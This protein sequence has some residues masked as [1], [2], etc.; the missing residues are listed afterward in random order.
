MR[1]V[2]EANET[3]RD[4]RGVAPWRGEGTDGTTGG[5]V[6]RGDRSGA[7]GEVRSGRGGATVGASG[8]VLVVARRPDIGDAR[9][10]TTGTYLSHCS[11]CA[12]RRTSVNG[13]RMDGE[14]W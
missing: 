10:G 9:V 11:S 13:V 6:V 4:L 1:G 14:D 12:R 7:L 3:M 5:V 8:M 2:R